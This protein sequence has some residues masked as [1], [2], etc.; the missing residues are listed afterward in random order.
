ML[1]YSKERNR[2][3]DILAEEENLYSLLKILDKYFLYERE[4]N[5]AIKTAYILFDYIRRK[6][7]KI[8]D[9]LDNHIT[10]YTEFI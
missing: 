3:L 5:D 8:I 7:K 4:N 1:P 2:L 6:Y 9:K 10:E